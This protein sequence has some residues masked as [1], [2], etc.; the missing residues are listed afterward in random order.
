MPGLF[1]VGDLL[2]ADLLNLAT[3]RPVCSLHQTVSQTGIAVTTD[4]ILSYTTED[5]DQEGWHDNVTNNSRIT[6]T[7]AGYYEVTVIGTWVASTTIS[8]TFASIYKN[9]AQY[10]RAGND[11]PNATS[12]LSLSTPTFTDVV[13]ID[14]VA[15]DY[16]QSAIQYS[17]TGPQATNVTGSGQSKFIVRYLGPA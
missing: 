3:Y 13:L 6:P 4:V 14:P 2:T 7:L 15:G 17:G 12:A 10:S 1:E 8:S 11:K 16:L 5:V 9:G